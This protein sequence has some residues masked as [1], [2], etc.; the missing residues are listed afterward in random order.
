MRLLQIWRIE[1][2]IRVPSDFARAVAEDGYVGSDRV[3]AALVFMEGLS[4]LI[5]EGLIIRDPRQS[6]DF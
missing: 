5:R 1:D 6:N 4:Y 2:R 3:R